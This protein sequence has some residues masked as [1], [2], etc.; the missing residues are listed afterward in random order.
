MFPDHENLQSH[1]TEY[2][3]LRVSANSEIIYL[4][5]GAILVRPQRERL[6]SV[7][8]RAE[9][10]RALQKTLP[11]I[12]LFDAFVLDYFPT[13]KRMF[14]SGMDR[15]ERTNL[16]LES[17]EVSE[18]LKKLAEHHSEELSLRGVCRPLD[19]S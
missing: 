15:T 14:S 18:L 8:P 17:I 6:R 11:T 10:R 19:S 2:V 4:E 9:A 1:S 16:L 13:V 12:S 3:T 5:D 7:P